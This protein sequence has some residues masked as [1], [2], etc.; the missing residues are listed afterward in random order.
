MGYYLIVHIIGAIVAMVLFVWSFTKDHDIT[1]YDLILFV[2]LSTL[3]SW[4][5]ALAIFLV[6]SGDMVIIKKRKK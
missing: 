2:L 4:V 1:L 3:F 5:T 6:D